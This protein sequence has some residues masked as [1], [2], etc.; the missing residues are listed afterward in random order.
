MLRKRLEEILF[1]QRDAGWRSG[2]TRLAVAVTVIKFPKGSF[3]EE[4][5]DTVESLRGRP[6]IAPRLSTRSY[7]L[8]RLSTLISV[9][10]WGASGRRSAGTVAALQFLALNG[11]VV[12]FFPDRW[13]YNSHLNA[14]LFALGMIDTSAHWAV[15]PNA[16][17]ADAASLRLQ[18]MAL[19]FMQL[20]AGVCYAQSALSK[21]RYGGVAWMSSGRTLRGSVAIMGTPAGHR[22]YRHKALFKIMSWGTFAFEAGFLPALVIFWPQRRLLG[23]SAVSFHIS[24]ACLMAISFWHLRSQY[25]TLLI[26]SC[27]EDARQRRGI[28]AERAAER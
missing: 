1:H 15:K 22:I 18:S 13:N 4:H 21:L 2:A 12:A 26:L 3:F 14:N 28:G 20:G 24:V 9:A 6:R 8:L 7:E 10:A 11:R 27:P 23:L 16:G 25:P 19:A 5:R 17:A